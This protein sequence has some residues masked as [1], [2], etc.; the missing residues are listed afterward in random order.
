MATN[1]Y[2]DLEVVE[3]LGQDVQEELDKKVDSQ[4]EHGLYP[5]ADKSKL[6]GIEA[7]AQANKI[8]QIEL[9][10]AAFTIEGKKA[11]GTIDVITP[12]D[13]DEAVGDLD[14]LKEEDLT[15]YA[16]TA[17]VAA[18][19]AEEIEKLGI[20]DY[21]KKTE[22]LQNI[23]EEIAKLGTL[24]TFADEPLIT[25]SQM[26]TIKATAKK[27]TAY[28]VTDDNNHLV[29]YF[30]ADVAGTDAN[31]FYDTGL[32][33]DLSGYLTEIPTATTEEVMQKWNAG[34]AKASQA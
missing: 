5:D 1:K 12:D 26:A 20:A 14:Y 11:T 10:G 2:I 3:N 8:E 22:V 15:D 32:H 13:L 6:S 28:L 17:A 4:A 24:F 23:A 7:N 19:I 21:A 18:K 29:F 25:K 34:K 27:G 16:K 33:V 30:G 9:N 31:G